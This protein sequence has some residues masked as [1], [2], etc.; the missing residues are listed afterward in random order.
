MGEHGGRPPHHPAGVPY[1][2]F[3]RMHPQGPEGL[4]RYRVPGTGRSLCPERRVPGH[5]GA[6]C[7]G[8]RGCEDCHPGYQCRLPYAGCA[9]NALPAAPLRSRGTGRAA[10]DLAAG[11]RY[12]P[13]RGRGRRLQLRR[14][15]G[16]GGPAALRRHGHLHHLQEQHLQ[17]HAP[18]GYRRAGRGRDGEG[19]ETVRI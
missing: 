4:G 18:A 5:P 2:S 16:S 13:V 15:P 1:S 12:L 8:K 9:G 3:G 14:G 19:A 6:G 10:S 17:R 7:G 11:Q